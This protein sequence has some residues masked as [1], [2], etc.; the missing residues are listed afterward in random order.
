MSILSTALLLQVC[1][2]PLKGFYLFTFIFNDFV[3]LFVWLL[4]VV[5]DAIDTET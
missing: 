2:C 4:V 5:V 1:D 3:C